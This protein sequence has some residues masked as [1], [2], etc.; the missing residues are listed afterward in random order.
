MFENVV[1]VNVI[2]FVVYH[3]VYSTAQVK[4]L[5]WVGI[6]NISTKICIIIT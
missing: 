6:C 4:V 3:K 1:E 2:G 5:S